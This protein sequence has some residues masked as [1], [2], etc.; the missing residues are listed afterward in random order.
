MSNKQTEYSLQALK[1]LSAD[2]SV[3]PPIPRE[4]IVGKADDGKYYGL[5]VNSDGTLDNPTGSA[6]SDNQTQQNMNRQL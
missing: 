2:L 3:S 6:T 5:K 1:N 4:G